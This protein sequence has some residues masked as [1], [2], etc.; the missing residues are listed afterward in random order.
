MV[1][2]HVEQMRKTFEKVF[3]KL[4]SKLLKQFG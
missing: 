4:L 2:E 1:V 3:L